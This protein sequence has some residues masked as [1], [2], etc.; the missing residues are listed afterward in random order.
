MRLIRQDTRIYI[1]LETAAIFLLTTL[2][3]KPSAAGHSRTVG[4]KSLFYVIKVIQPSTTVIH[5]NQAFPLGK[6][7]PVVL[8]YLHLYWKF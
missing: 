6:T 4:L 7:F 5:G 8:V 3:K 1:L 2:K